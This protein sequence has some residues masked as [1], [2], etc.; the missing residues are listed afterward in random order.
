MNGPTYGPLGA[1]TTVPIVALVICRPTEAKMSRRT[2][3]ADLLGSTR[4]QRTAR[5]REL[6]DVFRTT[7]TGGQVVATSGVAILPD[8]VKA[9]A[10]LT[11]TKFDQFSQDNDPYG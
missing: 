4:D 11:V 7:F 5:I 10:F 1:L 9:Q 3:M 8:M 6:N 2:A